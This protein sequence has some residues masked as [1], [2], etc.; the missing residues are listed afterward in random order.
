MSP[1]MKRSLPTPTRRQSA[2]A[3]LRKTHGWIGLWG[4]TLGLLFG[5]SGIFLNHRAVLPLKPALARSQQEIELP[6]PGPVDAA[7]M[8][9]WL[10]V[11]LG[12]PGPATMIRV[13][14]SAPMPPQTRV[15]VKVLFAAIGY[16]SGWFR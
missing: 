11:Q 4:A 15:G 1:S 7:T 12:L 8:G 10:Q 5:T 9:A 14:P 16:C 3:W 2:I 6:R 13:M